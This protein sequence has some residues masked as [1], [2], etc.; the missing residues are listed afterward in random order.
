MCAKGAKRIWDLQIILSL[1][2]TWFI[3]P[4]ST[5]KSGKKYGYN[6]PKSVQKYT[7]SAKNSMEM[8]KIFTKMSRISPKM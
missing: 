1:L 3:N 2:G 8:Y 7:K 4:N 6:Q 5:D